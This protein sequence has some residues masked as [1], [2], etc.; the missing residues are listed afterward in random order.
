MQRLSIS[1]IEVGSTTKGL[2]APRGKIHGVVVEPLVEH[3]DERGRLFEF[4]SGPSEFWAEPLVWGHCFTILPRGAKGWGVHLEKIDR[5]CLIAGEV[6]TVLYDSRVA[7]PTFRVIQEIALSP[8]GN[9]ILKIPA[10]VWHLNLN[11]TDSEAYLIDLPTEPYRHANPDKLVLP[12]HTTEIPYK[13]PKSLIE[14]EK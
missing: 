3:V 8:G 11:L 5:Y 13:V 7:S 2:D 10:G 12:W 4:F 1:E 9:R 14:D 6:M